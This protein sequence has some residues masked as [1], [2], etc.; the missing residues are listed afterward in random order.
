MGYLGRRIGNSP[1]TGKD[2]SGVGGGLFDLF[3]A[4][5]FQ[6][7]GNMPNSPGLMPQGL[8]ATGGVIS[9]IGRASCR[10]RV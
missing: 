9:E 2:T 7:T 8:S 1:T 3:T 4:G 6:R 10:D 5:Y